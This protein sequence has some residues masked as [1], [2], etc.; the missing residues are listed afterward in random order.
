M[1]SSLQSFC[2]RLRSTESAFVLVAVLLVVAL[3][4]ILVVVTSMMAQIER[5][6]AANGAKVEQARAN[7]LFALDV[8]LNQ[9]Q[10]SAGPDQR[11]TARAE[12]FDTNSIVLRTD[13]VKQPLWTGVWK[14]GTNQ[15]DA[16]SQPQRSLSFGSA[17]PDAAQKAASATWLVSGQSP[18]DPRTFVGGGNGTSA[19]SALLATKPGTNAINVEVPLVLMRNGAATNGAYA[20]W[21]SDEGLKA[22]VNIQDPTYKVRP[23]ADP[24]LSQA[25]FTSLQG[26]GTSKGILGSNNSNDLR[27]QAAGLPKVTT[28]ES[29]RL[30]DS[31]IA[32]I[33]ALKPDAT[34]V[35]WGVFAD[36]RRGGLR[37]DLT[38]ILENPSVY[39][40]FTANT[41]YGYGSQ[42]IYRTKPT[43]GLVVPAP[44][45]PTVAPFYDSV[46]QSGTN[47]PV[48][49]VSW[50]SLY[51]FYNSYKRTMPAPTGLGSGGTAPTSSGSPS[52]MPFEASQR[53]YSETGPVRDGFLMPT[54]VAFR[55]DIAISSYNSAVGG[56]PNWKLRLHYYPQLVLHNPYSVRLPVTNFQIERR[57]GAFNTAGSYGNATGTAAG[58]SASLTV[59]RVLSTTAGNTT[60]GPWFKVNQT[61][62]SVAG[63]FT[64]RNKAG[65]CVLD[66][67]ETRV[68]A[69]DADDRTSAT[70]AQAITFS[71]LVSNPNMSPDYSRQCDVLTAATSG[72]AND[73]DNG[74]SNG[75]PFATS[76][77]S[78]TIRVEL[79]NALLRLQNIDTFVLPNTL[80]WPASDSSRVMTG[81]GGSNLAAAAGSW[82]T[83]RIDQLTNPR[84]VIGF[85]I[86]QKG[87]RPSSSIYSY[88]NANN[89][90]P[91]YMGNFAALS[92]VD[93]N[94]S[95]VWREIYLSPFG[96]LYQNGQTDVNISPSGSFWETS[97]GD[98]SVG[99]AGAASRRVLRDVPT[100][101]LLSIGQFMHMS[102][103]RYTN[104]T[105][106]YAAYGTGSMFVGGSLASPGIPTDYNA[107]AQIQGYTG[108]NPQRTIY[109]DDSFLA[110]EALFDRYFFS[111]V[112]PSGA[113]PSGT[114]WP[115][116]WTA[117]NSANSGSRMSDFSK[118]L[119][120][121]RIKPYTPRGVAPLM[122]DL[123]DA[124]K[125]AANLLLDGAFN[126]N[127]TSVEAWKAFLAGASGNEIRLWDA[128]SRSAQT[129]A[130]TSGTPF[131]RFWSASSATAANTLWSGLRILSN[132]ELNELAQRIVTEVK[133]RGPFLSLADF[134]NRRLGPNS[135][136][137]NRCGA[138]QA[139]IDKTNPNLNA[140]IKQSGV[141]V[142]AS[143]PTEAG[144]NGTYGI[145]P[146]APYLLPE[147]MKD[148]SGSPWNTALGVPGY[149]MQ[150]DIVQTIAPA[151]AARSDT[152][153]VR[154]Y[155]ENR[156]PR[157]GKIEGKAWGEAVVQR[158]PDLVDG[159][160]ASE[161]A[162]ASLNSTNQ[163]LGRRFKVVSFRWLN[164]NEV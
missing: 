47:P 28:P 103:T 81:G 113:A 26:V 64:L 117:F 115:S 129:V 144:N 6:A 61:P 73:G 126:V 74:I 148:A 76:D 132:S 114:T 32:N 141:A 121:S 10:T 71:D 30:L 110:N 52:T 156:N 140:T 86:R 102:A 63:R 107:L 135:T 93:D 131:S 18:L 87:L 82:A 33:G 134:L 9:L 96:G 41:T 35:S 79:K 123:R 119:L 36:V 13:V 147:N 84:R 130:T 108:T 124:D 14:T 53:V 90:I 24:S 137:E 19:T 143:I 128:A 40:S 55:L 21:V 94:F 120:N 160:Q 97:I 65:D 23:D 122:A 104:S 163:T 149:L 20:Y 88:S 80:R 92:P 125:A 153:V 139:A 60:T 138:L 27:D 59:M 62:S 42:M 133:L 57:I 101:P 22:K 150:Q 25:H 31:S 146:R 106:D 7:A 50:F 142:N 67:G 164:E 158:L 116:A 112:P 45:S 145:V 51:G 154:T 68:F 85:Y 12:I 91:L 29:L 161:T 58:A 2:R 152:F 17:T 72:Q 49:G 136:P 159:S 151:I 70:P 98:E 105:G 157:T 5:T 54:P 1:Q 44:A 39:A 99:V 95:Y 162:A 43:Y 11:I 34:T 118:P 155:G 3:A 46:D 111:T 69:L 38:A 16:G 127:S 109:T 100:Q 48:D 37:K 89:T 83:V 4:T 8:A 66:P 78:T 15:L 56:T 75:P 77:P